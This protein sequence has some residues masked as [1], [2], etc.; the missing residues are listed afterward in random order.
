MFVSNIKV[1]ICVFIIQCH[2]KPELFL[3]AL[4]KKPIISRLFMRIYML[5]CHDKSGQHGL[6]DQ[7]DRQNH[8]KMT[9]YK[10]VITE[11]IRHLMGD[12][13][14]LFIAW[15]MGQSLKTATIMFLIFTR[16]D[17]GRTMDTIV[18]PTIFINEKVF[19]PGRKSC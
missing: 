8:N 18:L 12:K 2:W 9:S 3:V 16:E 1:W 4:D 6:Y 19:I 13:G 11:R 14:S 5:L 15:K 10:A 17:I 7:K